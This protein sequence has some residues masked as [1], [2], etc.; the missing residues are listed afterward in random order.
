[1]VNGLGSGLVNGIWKVVNKK[2]HIIC[3][4]CNGN[5]ELYNKCI[6]KMP[7]EISLKK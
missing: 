3:E 5:E 4:K 2:Q 1:M 6:S 7:S